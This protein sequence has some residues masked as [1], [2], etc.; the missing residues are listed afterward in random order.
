M[1]N[2]FDLTTADGRKKALQAF[3]KY[4][5]AIS[6]PLWLVKNVFEVFSTSDVNTIEAQRKAAIDLIKVGRDN[7]VDEMKITMDQTAGLDLAS[8]VEG[9][10][11][12]C[13]IGK[14]GHMVVE[15]RY[16]NV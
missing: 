12:K 2:N 6:L 14:S 1:K 8:E 3:D 7:N 4:G 15:V 5:W 10:P 11:I 9:I 13:K 16:K